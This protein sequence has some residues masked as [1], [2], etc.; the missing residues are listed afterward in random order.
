MWS[1]TLG[2]MTLCLNT[3]WRM[4]ALNSEYLCPV[5]LLM[6]TLFIILIM[7]SVII[8]N[9]ILLSVIVLMII[10]QNVSMDSSNMLHVIMFY[11]ITQDATKTNKEQS[12]TTERLRHTLCPSLGLC[13]WTHYKIFYRCYKFHAFVLLCICHC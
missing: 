10:I 6:S 5:V 8:L 2:L 11:A 9:F 12:T 3:T 4:S 13:G 7:L 1:K